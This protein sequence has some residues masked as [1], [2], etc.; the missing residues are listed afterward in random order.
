[1]GEFLTEN[2]LECIIWGYPHF[3]KP[4]IFAIGNIGLSIGDLHQDPVYVTFISI[5]GL[6]SSFWVSAVVKQSQVPRRIRETHGKTAEG[7][8]RSTRRGQMVQGKELEENVLI[9][10]A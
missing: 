2:P 1:M 9:K 8:C 5:L 3:R 6:H 4:R 7:T 10:N